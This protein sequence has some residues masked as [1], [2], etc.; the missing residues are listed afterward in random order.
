MIVGKRN[1]GHNNKRIIVE[2]IEGGVGDGTVEM[3]G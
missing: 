1:L 3:R 2:Q